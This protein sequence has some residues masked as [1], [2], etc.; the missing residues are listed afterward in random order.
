MEEWLTAKCG[1]DRTINA[2][3]VYDVNAAHLICKSAA[4]EQ[5]QR[6]VQGKD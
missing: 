4:I 2:A 6:R 3:G 5:E 1:P